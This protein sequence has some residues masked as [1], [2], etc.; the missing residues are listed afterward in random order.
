MQQCVDGLVG[1]LVEV[2]HMYS[3]FFS[4]TTQRVCA[5]IVLIRGTETPVQAT[6]FYNSELVLE[7]SPSAKKGQ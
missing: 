7:K 4:T 1:R 2:T 3:R 5:E 6:Q